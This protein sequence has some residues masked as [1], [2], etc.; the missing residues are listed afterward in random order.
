M[1]MKK[2]KTFSIVLLFL[3]G[4]IGCK[5]EEIPEISGEN[6]ET[7]NNEFCLYLNSE[8]MDETMPVMN[9]YLEKLPQNLS[10][11]QKLEQLT[12]WLKSAPCI[13]D[14][15]ILCESCISGMNTQKMSEILIT[16]EENGIVKEFIYDILMT[17]PLQ[18]AF[19]HREY[20]PMH[21]SVKTKRY[22]TINEIFDFINSLD[23]DIKQIFSG[24]YVSTMSSD[25]LQY[26]L[27]RLNEKPYTNNGTDWPRVTGYL[28][29]LTNQITIFPYLFNMKNKAY[30]DDWL[31]AMDEYKL[32]EKFDYDHSG[33]IIY[34]R[35]PEGTE[36][37][38][39]TQFEKYEFVVW[40]DLSWILH[41]I[42]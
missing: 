42:P 26:I 23:L 16:F 8:N 25:N 32:V 12:N 1:N 22:F 21:V 5:K 11:K 15:T 34:F 14:A 18:V 9:E 10:D 35:V 33:Y 13:I 2:L 6:P 36:K 17:N 31:Q 29:Y 41:L 7:D 4:L 19:C 40:A 38:W 30:Q 20:V 24:V 39:V 28:H 3:L 27:D 37:Y